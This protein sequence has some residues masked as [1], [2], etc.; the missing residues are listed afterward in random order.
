MGTYAAGSTAHL[1]IVE[2]NKQ[3]GLNIEAVHYR[4]EAPMWAD[5]NGQTLDAAIGSYNAALPV[6]Q[7]GRGKALARDRAAAPARAARC[8]DDGGAR[9]EIQALR[10]ARLHL[11]RRAR[12]HA[13][14]H[15]QET[16]RRHRRRRQRPE[17]EG[18]DGTSSSST[19]RSRTRRRKSSSPSRRRCGCSSWKAWGSSR[20]KPGR[21]RPRMRPSPG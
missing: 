17:G 20:K 4:G 6:M 14:R 9:R 8:A 15:R 12:R 1:I 18:D 19:R 2:L 11:L 16:L 13:A 5:I 7:G 21:Q 10:A 3:Y